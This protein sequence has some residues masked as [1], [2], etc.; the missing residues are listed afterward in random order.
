MVVNYSKWEHFEEDDESSAADAAMRSRLLALHKSDPA[1]LDQLDRELKEMR[2]QAERARAGAPDGPAA[3][4]GAAPH[5]HA[6]KGIKANLKASGATL[7]SELEALEAE[8]T[9]MA[10]QEARLEQLAACG[11]ERALLDFFSQQGFS[12]EDLQRALGGDIES[13]V[14]AKLAAKPSANGA[15]V[16]KALCIA[17]TIHSVING[18]D[19]G[20]AESVLRIEAPA[21]RPPPPPPQKV[22]V[23]PVV[24]QRQPTVDDAS[25]VVTIH[26]PELE[27]ARGVDVD[28]ATKHIRLAAR[29]SDSREYLATV[30]L[31]RRV[32][33]VKSVAKWSSKKRELTLIIPLR[34]ADE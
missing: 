19:V 6:A 29:I 24:H 2:L 12:P 16:D 21:P 26:L 1:Q 4:R 28:V 22:M 18:G 20:T 34:N 25:I 31:S 9:S 27:S 14:Q 32:D 15:A 30:A 23:Q 13:T 7:K 17:E 3:A 10:T 8:R 11:D 33:E 5:K